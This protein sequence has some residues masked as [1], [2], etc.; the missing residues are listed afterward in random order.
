MAGHGGESVRPELGYSV[1]LKPFFI[2]HIC[3]HFG[4]H[5]IIMK[6]SLKSCHSDLIAR[7]VMECLQIAVEYAG[8]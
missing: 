5:A 8:A 4:S 7:R 2:R 3:I 1:I 6:T